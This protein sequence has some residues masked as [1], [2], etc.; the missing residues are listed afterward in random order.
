MTK[1]GYL[2]VEETKKEN[3]CKAKN[4]SI[5]SRLAYVLNWKSPVQLKI[6]QGF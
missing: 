4:E 5:N 2:E 3:F 6:E 1:T